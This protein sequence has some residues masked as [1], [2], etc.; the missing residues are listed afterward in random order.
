MSLLWIVLPYEMNRDRKP[1]LETVEIGWSGLV[2]QT[3]RFCQD[4]RQSGVPPSFDK[5]H[6][7]RPSSIWTVERHKP[8]QLRRLWLWLRDLI[9]KMKR[10]EN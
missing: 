5:V 1:L 7:L 4:R 6:L 3:I 2:N 8:Q 10:I 9:E